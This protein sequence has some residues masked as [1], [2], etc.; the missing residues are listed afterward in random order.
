[1]TN[2]FHNPAVQCTKYG[3]LFSLHF[4]YIVCFIEV[5]EKICHIYVTAK[6]YRIPGINKGR[7]VINYYSYLPSIKAVSQLHCNIVIMYT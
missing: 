6:H 3:Q 5:V 4:S 2:V 1:M 7:K